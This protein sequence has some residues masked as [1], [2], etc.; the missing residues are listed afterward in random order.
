[1]FFLWIFTKDQKLSVTLNHI[2]Y[3]LILVMLLI[4][5][6]GGKTETVFQTD[7]SYESSLENEDESEA[8]ESA[9]FET[10]SENDEAGQNEGKIVIYICGAVLNPGVYTFS[11]G[12]RVCDAVEAAGGLGENADRRR[13]NQ[14]RLL[15][16][17]EE[18]IVYENGEEAEVENTTQSATGDGSQGLVNI[19]T[20]DQT[21]LKTL[22]GI[23]DVKALAIIQYRQENGAFKTIEEIKSVSGIGDS[24]FNS[25]KDQITVN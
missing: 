14:A 6:C 5:G 24:L 18:I 21:T 16:D 3:P 22:S 15:T 25:I 23:G 4:T 10:S 12:A 9:S 17:G 1:M 13:L 11:E 19:N 2:F 7:E 8:I 20:A